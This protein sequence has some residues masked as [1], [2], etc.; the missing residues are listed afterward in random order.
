MHHLAFDKGWFE[1]HQYALI[2]LLNKPLTRRWFRWVLRIRIP[3]D[4]RI[5]R[6]APNYFFYDYKKNSV[7]GRFRTHWKYSK[8]LYHAFKPLWWMMHF[9]DWLIADRFIPRWS[10]GFDTLTKS[11][12]AGTGGTTTDAMVQRSSVNEAFS[13]IRSGA[14]TAVDSGTLVSVTLSASSTTNQF[15]TMR[16]GILTFDLSDIGGGA[17]V[18]SVVLSLYEL[19]GKL[20][21]IGSPDLHVAGAT[22]ASNSEI[23][24]SDFSEIE[25][26]S[27]GSI[28]YASWTNSAYNDITFNATGEA[29][30]TAGVNA[31]SLQTSW[32]LSGTFGGSWV[33][34]NTSGFFPASADQTG[35]SN[36]PVMEVDFTPSTFMPKL[37]II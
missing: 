18:N 36:D 35:T 31:F 14:G 16:R 27:F 4:K 11:P 30:I 5:V 33:S 24:A 34:G 25:R 32:D 10:F 26:T 37:I 6:I 7:K 12:E 3:P 15:S 29:A 19:V 20:N 28:S 17:A 1:K 8:R 21:N 2:W 9:W 23:V 22:P 13:T